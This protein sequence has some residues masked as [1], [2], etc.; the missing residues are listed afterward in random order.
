MPIRPSTRAEVTR[1]ISLLPGSSGRRLAYAIRAII[2]T[3]RASLNAQRTEA[4][5]IGEGGRRMLSAVGND[6]IKKPPRA[7]DGNRG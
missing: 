4:L 7:P 2:D 6:R 5:L 3:Y 1:T